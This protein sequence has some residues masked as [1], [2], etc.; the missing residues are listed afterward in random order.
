MQDNLP[1]GALT[2]T[3]NSTIANYA[4]TPEHQ[5]I[6]IRDQLL[7]EWL[8][9]EENLY[10]HLYKP[11]EADIRIMEAETR[12]DFPPM[13]P[14]SRDNR[15]RSQQY[16]A[17]DRQAFC[18]TRRETWRTAGGPA[19][20]PDLMELLDRAIKVTGL[21]HFQRQIEFTPPLDAWGIVF[22]NGARLPEKRVKRLIDEIAS[23]FISLGIRWPAE[24]R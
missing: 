4:K 7:I 2:P 22:R 16:E 21:E 19:R 12:R 11:V 9:K 18:D 10:I 5:A 20:W 23:S 8:R 3:Q 14:P 15:I 17:L 1:P 24:Y 6:L 13:Y